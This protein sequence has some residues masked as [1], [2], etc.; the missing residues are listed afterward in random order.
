VNQPFFGSDELDVDVWL[1]YTKKFRRDKVRWTA[2]LNVRDVFGNDDLIAVTAQPNGTIA[3]A[4]I[5]QPTLWSLT[6]TFSF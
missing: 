2:Q 4:R 3:S 5:P 1:R 6:N